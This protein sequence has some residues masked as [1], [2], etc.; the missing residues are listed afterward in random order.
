ME[1]SIDFDINESLKRYL[2]DPASILTPEADS[3]LQECE[4]DPDSLSAGLVNS[5]LDPI[6]D[7]I[8]ENPEALVQSSI[9][10]T[11]QFLL[12]C[13]PT[14]LPASRSPNCGTQ[15][16]LFE[17]SRQTSRLP[18]QA[19]N[20]LFDL[21]I[22]SLSAA[23]DNIGN[24]LENEDPDTLRHYKRLLEMY[25]FIL[26][27][28]IAVVEIKAA[29]KSMTEPARGRGSKAVKSKIST[30]ESAW[31]SSL[32]IQ[33]ALDVICKVLKLR[34]GKVFVTTSERDTFVSLFTRSVY[35]IMESEQR[36]KQVAVR[37][38][39]FKVIC[40]AIKHHGHAFGKY[41]QARWQSSSSRTLSRSPNLYC[42][43]PDVL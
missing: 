20:K 13:A 25:A 30:K 43:E 29:E 17:L 26:Q 5:V 21:I 36:V 7:A 22:S 4:T 27:W 34:L 1:N 10:D 11:L 23:A 6:V 28:T 8:A 2:N 40:I 12:K 33:A 31:D 32:Q 16:E 18:V 3:A 15:S 35:L 14:F 39:A 42:S 9:F 24:D 37:M 41:D 38:H 19:L